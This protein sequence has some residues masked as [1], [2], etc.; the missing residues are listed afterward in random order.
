MDKIFIL[1]LNYQRPKETIECLH[2]IVKFSNCQIFKL[3]IILIDNGSQDE[4]VELIRK[5]FPH[6]KII[7]NKK[8]LGFAGGNNVGI[9]Y[10]LRKSADFILLLNNDTEVYSDFLIQLIKVMRKDKNVGI[11]GPVI[12]HK[13]KNKT[14]YDYGGKINFKLA[15]AYHI[16]KRTYQKTKPIERDFVSG[17]CM[18][19]KK[20]V[21]E[22][23]GF[24]DER[25]FLYLEDVDFCVRVKKVGYKIWMVP[26]VKIFH[27]GGV[28]GDD[29]I[30]I[31]YS[32]RNSILFTMKWV[33]FLYKPIALIYNLIF[34][35]YLAVDWN[36]KRLKQLVLKLG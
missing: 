35:P 18:L 4:S 25:Y 15:R 29:W 11:A 9:K 1:I 22:K 27:Y 31:L 34:Y 24:L 16:N 3:S 32:F 5:K 23:V 2:S 36:L 10:A 26:A 13:V 17:C 33:P 12:E 21:F 19:I 6:L 28:S 30:K 14:F 8:N 7:E 20:E